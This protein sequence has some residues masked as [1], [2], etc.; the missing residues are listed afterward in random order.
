MKNTVLELEQWLNWK[1]SFLHFEKF[2]WRFNVNS[3]ES[4]SDISAFCESGC[5][6]ISI[7]SIRNQKIKV[8]H[9]SNCLL[10]LKSEENDVISFN[11][12]GSNDILLITN[13]QVV[14]IID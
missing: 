9:R 8:N 12:F 2:Q 3:K 7:E 5:V 6:M 10:I 1:T 4:W 13:C 11:F 14:E